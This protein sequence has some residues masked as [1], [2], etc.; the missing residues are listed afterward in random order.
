M[1]WGKDQSKC[2]EKLR[3]LLEHFEQ[4]FV[5]HAFHDPEHPDDLPAQIVME[6]RAGVNWKQINELGVAVHRCGQALEICEKNYPA[7]FRIVNGWQDRFAKLRRDL[8]R[9]VAIGRGKSDIVEV[10][11]TFFPFRDAVVGL[12]ETL[13]GPPLIDAPKSSKR[14]YRSAERIAEK[15][16]KLASEGK[17]QR[18]I[19]VIVDRSPGRIS[20][21]LRSKE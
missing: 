10:A 13:C 20:Q 2:V 14:R 19:A 7:V 3:E 17:S 12:M 15:V 4:L 8:S 21:I 5:V 6:R 16:F 18:E 11:E 1:E 9:S